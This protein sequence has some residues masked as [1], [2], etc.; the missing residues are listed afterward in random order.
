[1][2]PLRAGPV[3]LR[4][5]YLDVPFQIEVRRGE[6]VLTAVIRDHKG[7]DGLMVVP[8]TQLATYDS[9]ATIW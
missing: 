9:P 4:S 1:V 6:A 2:V 7:L 3:P 8:K 5:L